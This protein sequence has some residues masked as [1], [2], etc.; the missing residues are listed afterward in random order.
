MLLYYITV[1][2][3]FLYS[4]K[5]L[6]VTFEK[7]Q[8]SKEADNEQTKLIQDEKAQVGKVYS[9]F[10]NILW[11]CINHILFLSTVHVL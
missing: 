1:H 4:S 7:L 5:M 3:C 9:S 8:T 2:Y 10:S 6:P 11:Q